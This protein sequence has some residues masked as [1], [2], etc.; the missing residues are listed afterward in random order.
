MQ[1]ERGMPRHMY[2][3]LQ[4]LVSIFFIQFDVEGFARVCANREVDVSHSRTRVTSRLHLGVTLHVRPT[5][6]GRAAQIGAF[7]L[8]NDFLHSDPFHSFVP[9]DPLDEP[10]VQ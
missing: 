7:E 2:F 8:I 5:L 6:Y 3:R 4:N 9:V 10:L 1:E